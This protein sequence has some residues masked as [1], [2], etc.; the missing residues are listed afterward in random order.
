MNQEVVNPPVNNQSILSLV[1]GILTILSFCTGLV[2]VPFTGFICFPTSFLLGILAI[3][4]GAVSLNRI[5]QQKESGRPMA[6]GGIM[7]GGLV[8]ICMMCMIIAIASFFIYTH[9]SIS[10]PPFIQNFSI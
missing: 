6:W 10:T 2:P 9:N 7:I 3:V 8:F 4:F 5:R 1:F